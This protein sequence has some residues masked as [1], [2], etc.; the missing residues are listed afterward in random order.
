M[1]S[2]NE[3][4]FTG[5]FRDIVQ[6]MRYDVMPVEPLTVAVLQDTIVLERSRLEHFFATSKRYFHD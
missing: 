4:T 1:T 3:S 2:E 5:D 6:G